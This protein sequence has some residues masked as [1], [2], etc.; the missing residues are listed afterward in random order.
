MKAA[1]TPYCSDLHAICLQALKDN[2]Q[3]VR[4]GG[5]KVLG[6]LM[7]CVAE[8]MSTELVTFETQNILQRISNADV[9]PQCRT[10]AEQ[11][12]QLG[13]PHPT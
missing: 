2:N 7:G 9:S 8:T 6:T 12:L 10:L 13:F 4:M 3:E 11:L 5:L 1:I